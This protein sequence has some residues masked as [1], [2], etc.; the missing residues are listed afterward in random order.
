MHAEAHATA[1]THACSKKRIACTSEALGK[2]AMGPRDLPNFGDDA[3]VHAF[4][5]VRSQ[6]KILGGGLGPQPPPPSYA[7]AFACGSAY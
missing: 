3:S 4:V 5:Q 2:C 6:P 1:C 7:T